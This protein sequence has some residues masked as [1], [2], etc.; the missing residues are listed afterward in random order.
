MATGLPHSFALAILEAS[1]RYVVLIRYACY[2][3]YFPALCR[4]APAA[5]PERP[6]LSPYPI[7]R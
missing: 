6:E 1:A 7:C 2:R 4:L 5:N 3:S